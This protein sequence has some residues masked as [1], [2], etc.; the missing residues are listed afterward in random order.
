MTEKLVRDSSEPGYRS[1]YC[2]SYTRPILRTYHYA[3]Y[4]IFLLVQTKLTSLKMSNSISDLSNTEAKLLLRKDWPEWYTQLAHHCRMN[5]IWDLINPDGPDA[6]AEPLRPP[7]L[8]SYED[9]Q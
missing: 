7:P 5:R 8:R 4:I 3:L 6:P 1:N 2:A 9:L